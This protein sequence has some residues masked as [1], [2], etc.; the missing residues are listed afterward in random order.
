MA[1][2]H[3]KACDLILNLPV[4]S[5][6]PGGDAVKVMLKE[7]IQVGH[8]VTFNFKILIHLNA[9]RSIAYLHVDVQ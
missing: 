4:W 8:N 3:Q 7:K 9:D 2:N 5:L 6:V 1:G